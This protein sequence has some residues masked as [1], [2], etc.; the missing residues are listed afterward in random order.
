MLLTIKHA[1]TEHNNYTSQYLL[2]LTAPST[3]NDKVVVLVGEQGTGNSTQ[4][5]KRRVPEAQLTIMP[6]RQTKV[7][8]ETLAEKQKNLCASQCTILG[9]MLDLHILPT[10]SMCQPALGSWID[11]TTTQMFHCCYLSI[12]IFHYSYST[13]PVLWLAAL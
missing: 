11:V 2:Y 5:G 3:Y 8:Q 9:N 1:Q 7:Q 13:I 4:N 12:H 6:M 10:S